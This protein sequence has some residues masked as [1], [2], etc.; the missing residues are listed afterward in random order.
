MTAPI[1]IRES[2]NGT[3][4]E[5]ASAFGAE[6]E[7]RETK[8][9]AAVIKP[10]RLCTRDG[11]DRKVKLPT[12][13]AEVRACRGVTELTDTQFL[14]SSGEYPVNTRLSVVRK[15]VIWMYATTAAV[16]GAD[17]YVYY[18]AGD[19]ALRGKVGGT[20][21][22]GQNARLP[23]AKFFTS[24]DADAMV[25][26]EFDLPGDTSS[27]SAAGRYMVAEVLI[28]AGV[29]SLST[30]IG[31]LSITDT[32]AGTFK[33][34]VAGAASVLPAGQPIL[35]R[36]TDST[37]DALPMVCEVS[38]LAATEVTYVTLVQQAADQLFDVAD[39]TTLSKVY[40]PLFVTYA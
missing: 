6:N 39:L 14:N 33:L 40:V 18:G 7:L 30:A 24:A 27:E 11:S 16:Q 1:D 22:S 25:A 20:F 37:V 8:T 4:L 2:V 10:G 36:A 26:V 21:S 5:G 9:N 29:P 3:M 28:T 19:T 32:A 35:E 17:V 38:V 31:G 13:A 15:G 12:T 23:G 34:T